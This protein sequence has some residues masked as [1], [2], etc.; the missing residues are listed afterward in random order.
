MEPEEALHQGDL[1]AALAGLEDRV[2][3]DPTEAR[4]RI[5]L[6]Q[7]LAVL[8][9]WERSLKQ[10]R[11]LADLDASHMP[12][13]WTYRA[14][15][16]GEVFREKIFRGEASPPLFG[17]PVAWT[18][19]L[20]EALR[21]TVT[22]EED[23]GEALRLEAFESAPA[24]TGRVGEEPFEWI[25]DAD[26][27][28]GP[29]V[30]LVVEGRYGWAPFDTI[31]WIEIDPPEDLRDLIWAPARL[32]WRNGGEANALIPVR[33]PGTAGAEDAMLRL[34]RRTEWRDCGS[35]CQAGLGQRMWATD[36][37]EHALLETRRIEL[38]LPLE[39]THTDHR[40]G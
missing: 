11:A 5:F 33:Y 14:A 37:A 20:L 29:M 22:G 30:E 31:R 8:G 35:N 38:D 7:L 18:A 16:Q 34:S 13:A 10:L 17:D 9:E 4:H 32:Q 39:E 1:Q 28:F 25:A 15:I 40:D 3:K 23:K 26:T 12:L 27:R 19:L 24:V 21:L 6:F 2:R 36:R